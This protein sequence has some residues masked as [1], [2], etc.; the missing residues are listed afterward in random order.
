MG[1]NLNAHAQLFY[2]YEGRVIVLIDSDLNEWYAYYFLIVTDDG[3]TREETLAVNREDS[4][5]SLWEA[6]HRSEEFAKSPTVF[7]TNLP[8]TPIAA[9][10]ELRD[11]I[12]EYLRRSIPPMR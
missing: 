2:D 12:L 4:D 10:T 11:N 6:H 5:F 1:F 3:I 9:Q 7:G 8:L